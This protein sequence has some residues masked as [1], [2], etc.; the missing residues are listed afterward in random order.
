MIVEIGLNAMP[1]LK[2]VQ[3]AARAGDVDRA[4]IPR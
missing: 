3:E 2:S 1:I 4:K